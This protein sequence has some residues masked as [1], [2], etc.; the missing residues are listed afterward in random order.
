M[1]ARKE[2]LENT[3]LL[4]DMKRWNDE[5]GVGDS[6]NIITAFSSCVPLPSA[7]LPS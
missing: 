5:E 6:M 4:H 2:L 1:F 7:R 3:K